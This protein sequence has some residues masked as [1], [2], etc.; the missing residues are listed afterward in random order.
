MTLLIHLR[1][2]NNYTSSQDVTRST[3][4]VERQFRLYF[5]GIMEN[6][7]FDQIIALAKNAEVEIVVCEYARNVITS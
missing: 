6:A 4:N 7:L 5:E 3:C 1:E 2:Y